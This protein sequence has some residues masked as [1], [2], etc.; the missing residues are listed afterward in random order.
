MGPCPKA[1]IIDLRPLFSSFF[2]LPPP[3]P[4][5]VSS[6]SIRTWRDRKVPVS[7]LKRKKKT[8]FIYNSPC[9]HASFICDLQLLL[10]SKHFPP[11]PILSS[12]EGPAPSL[13]SFSGSHNRNSAIN[14]VISKHYAGRTDPFCFFLCVSLAHFLTT[15]CTLLHEQSLSPP[16]RHA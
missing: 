16:S 13:Y 3:P 2:P 5:R 8:K 10:T 1:N 7:S 4:L 12:L 6:F 11:H 9:Q 15:R 14:A